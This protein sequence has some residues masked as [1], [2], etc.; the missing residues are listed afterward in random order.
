VAHRSSDEPYIAAH[1][2]TGIDVYEV[3][4]R[5]VAEARPAPVCDDC[6]VVESVQAVSQ[7]GEAKGIGAVAGGVVGGLLG[8]NIGKGTAATWPPSRHRRRRL[9]RAPDREVPAHHH[10]L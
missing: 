2:D 7:A 3:P 6:G 8:R 10:G 1:Q 4:R 9:C 5:P